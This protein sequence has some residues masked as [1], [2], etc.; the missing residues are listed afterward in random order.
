[1]EEGKKNP[2]P[3]REALS[4]YC[5][6][7]L[8]PDTEEHRHIGQCPECLARVEAYRAMGRMIRK[9]LESS[10]DADLVDRIRR[11]LR[12]RLAE[13]KAT[14]VPF[15][16]LVMRAAAAAMVVFTVY[17]V[18]KVGLVDDGAYTAETGV[19]VPVASEGAEPET[20][21]NTAPSKTTSAEV[22]FVKD[23]GSRPVHPSPDA[24]RNAVGIA[25]MK[26][27][28]TDAG[29]PPSSFVSPADT[30]NAQKVAPIPKI[31]RHVWVVKDIDKADKKLREVVGGAVAKDRIKARK[32]KDDREKIVVKKI[33]KNSL[34]NIVKALASEGYSL[35]TPAEP[36]PEA[37]RFEGNASDPV[38]YYIDLVRG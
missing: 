10:A 28:S 33:D 6:G 9:G 25:D 12:R 16:L 20:D 13:D 38:K 27:A 35:M 24:G 22:E 15:Q 34:V 37:D 7:I 8:G 21:A 26:N 11:D 36:Q 3:D 14:S 23:G 5:D 19:S 18:A 31:V 17:F 29:K 2:C 32:L 30:P 1:M 4:L